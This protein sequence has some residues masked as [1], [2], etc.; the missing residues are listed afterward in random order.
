M[1]STAETG[2]DD[3]G[4]PSCDFEG[5]VIHIPQAGNFLKVKRT[6]DCVAVSS[7]Q[8][9]LDAGM[10]L[11]NPGSTVSANQRIPSAFGR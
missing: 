8:P 2:G 3:H 1:G 9:D 11:L 7:D 5:R 6:G 4:R 10:F